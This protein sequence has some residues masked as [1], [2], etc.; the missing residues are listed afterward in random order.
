MT[1]FLTGGEIAPL[2]IGAEE[3]AALAEAQGIDGG[4]GAEDVVPCE[5]GADVFHLLGQVAEEGGAAVGRV[6][7]ADLDD[8]DVGAWVDGFG[9][10]GGL[11]DA[12]SVV[13]VAEAVPDHERERCQGG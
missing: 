10:L 6:G 1:R 9:K 5:L 2:D 8:M 11:F 7:V 4:S 13:G 12:V 3:L